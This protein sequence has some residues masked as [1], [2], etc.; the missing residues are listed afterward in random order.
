MKKVL[1]TLAAML[2][3]TTALS[4]QDNAIGLRIGA[5]KGIGAEISYQRYLSDINRME[6]DLGF[7]IYD[8][9]MVATLNGNYQWH[10]FLT[11]GL[12]VY[13]GPNLLM[14]LDGGGYFNLGFG[15]IA[16]I[17]YQF[18][19]PVQVSLDFRPSYNLG[20]GSLQGFDPYV[21]LGMRYAF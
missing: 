21:A 2:A 12:G 1:L 19:A 17:D 10:W 7:R 20:H 3:I 4:A 9:S 15:A 16:G 5:M 11:E 18:D 14:A 13:G 6:A 8:H